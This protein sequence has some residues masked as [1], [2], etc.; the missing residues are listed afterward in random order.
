MNYRNLDQDKR[1]KTLKDSLDINKVNLINRHGLICNS[2]LRW[3]SKKENSHEQIFFTHAFAVKS[4]I[5]GLVFRINKLCFAKIKYFRSHIDNF[6]PFIYKPETG[7][8]KTD[9][10]DSDFLKHK[11]SGLI[12]DYRFL[13]RITKIEDFRNF[14]KHLESFE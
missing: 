7:F 14:C 5:L 6:E 3:I 2:N 8:E 13:Q 10:W 4:D 1:D 12:I 9:L 11:A